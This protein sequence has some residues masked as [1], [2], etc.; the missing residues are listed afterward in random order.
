MSRE[1]RAAAERIR[2]GF[3]Y[4]ECP[5][6]WQEC[7]DAR[8]IAEQWLAE[9]PADDEEAIDEAWLKSV[10]FKWEQ[11]SASFRAHYRGLLLY[12]RVNGQFWLYLDSTYGGRV[13]PRSKVSS[14]RDVRTV[15]TALGIN[16]KSEAAV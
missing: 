13:V 11:E 15:A 10:G 4:A 5:D 9:H 2:G 6:N 16:L 7:N 8:L 14:R 1:L 12:V 3:N